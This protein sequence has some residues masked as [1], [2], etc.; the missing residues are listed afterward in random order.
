MNVTIKFNREVS[1]NE[2]REALVFAENQETTDKYSLENE[3]I[4][5][6]GDYASIEVLVDENGDFEVL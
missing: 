2:L 4:K 3:I 5:I 1:V 6:N